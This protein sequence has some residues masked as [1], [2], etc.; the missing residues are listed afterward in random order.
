M[1]LGRSLGNKQTY[2][3]ICSVKKNTKANK[4]RE[5]RK[6]QRPQQPGSSQN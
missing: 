5:G 4:R 6:R 2:R 1:G 3:A